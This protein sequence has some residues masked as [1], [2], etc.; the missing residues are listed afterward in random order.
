[1]LDIALG[2]WPWAS[3]RHHGPPW[4]TQIAEG[5]LMISFFC[6]FCKHVIKAADESA[7]T[8]IVC[9]QCKLDIRVPQP[10]APPEVS[11]TPVSVH[12]ISSPPSWWKRLL[13]RGEQHAGTQR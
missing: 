7:G 10:V 13:H 6:P 8:L 5:R 3:G 11:A 4:F 12:T 1:M 2:G 9:E